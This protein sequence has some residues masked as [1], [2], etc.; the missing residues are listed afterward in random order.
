MNDAERLRATRVFVA[1]L[2]DLLAKQARANA[3][4]PFDPRTF[5]VVVKE[6]GE[7]GNTFARRFQVFETVAG[8]SCPDFLQGMTAAQ[9]AGLI[10]RLNPT[11]QFFAVSM[12]PYLVEEALGA[13]EANDAREPRR[14]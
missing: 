7:G 3:A 6:L 9:S 8:K 4:V 14:R 11:Y 10:S 2:K 13:T 1:A 5:A 12:S